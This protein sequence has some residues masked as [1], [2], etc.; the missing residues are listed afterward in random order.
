M[1]PLQTS[2]RAKYTLSLKHKILKYERQTGCSNTQIRIL[3]ILTKIK[4]KGFPHN[5]VDSFSHI[6]MSKKT[7][8]IQRKGM[9]KYIDK[10]LSLKIQREALIHISIAQG[11]ELSLKSTSMYFQII[12][13]PLQSLNRPTLHSSQDRL[14]CKI[15]IMGKK[16]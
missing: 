12:H 11:P 16:T 13:S 4:E 2:V 6:L 15:I 10:K 1:I 7:T 14:R 5:L 9:K 3:L 8:L